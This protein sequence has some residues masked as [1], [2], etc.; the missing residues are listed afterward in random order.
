VRDWARSTGWDKTPPAPELPPHIVEQS[1]K[2][3]IEA[4]ERLTG[5][6]FSSWLD[7]VGSVA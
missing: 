7:S 6:S 5:K 1:Q 2:R 3:Y 4:Y